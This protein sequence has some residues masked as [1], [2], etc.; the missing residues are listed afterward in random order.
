MKTKFT[1][2]IISCTDVKLTE[3]KGLEKM[4]FTQYAEKLSTKT[5]RFGELYD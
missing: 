4:D 2:V 3:V 5:L 1:Y